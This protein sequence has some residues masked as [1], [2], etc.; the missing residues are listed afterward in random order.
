MRRG[1]NGVVG[2]A[3]R[4]SDRTK[5]SWDCADL[6]KIEGA[7]SS[8]TDAYNFR[9]RMIHGD[10]QIR[11]VFRDNEEESE[12]RSDEEYNSRMFAI[13]ILVLLLRFVI[14]K[15]ATE[16]RFKTALDD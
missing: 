8:L 13:G 9:S 7:I 15:N 5:V 16:I 6:D 1:R 12:K 3:R 14:S 4:R 2:R 11:S 10:R